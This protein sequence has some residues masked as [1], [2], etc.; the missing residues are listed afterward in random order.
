MA[1]LRGAI[2]QPFV[3]ALVE[4]ASDVAAVSRARVLGCAD[5]HD[6]TLSAWRV[7]ARQV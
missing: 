2:A 6:R 7:P 5:R 1:V 3:G 4:L